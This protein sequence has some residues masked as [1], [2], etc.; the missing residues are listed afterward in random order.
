LSRDANGAVQSV[1]VEGE[2][3]WVI[4]RNEDGSVASLSNGTTDVAVDR[5]AD[6]IVEGTTVTDL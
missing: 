1:T 4:T 3:A 2:A 6:G 5:D